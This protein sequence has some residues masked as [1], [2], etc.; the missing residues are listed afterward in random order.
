MSPQ[1]LWEL[2]LPGGQQTPVQPNPS[3]H[4]VLHA[5]VVWPEAEQRHVAAAAEQGELQLAP[6]RVQ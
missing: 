4:P 6:H 3:D 2:F 5:P 1:P